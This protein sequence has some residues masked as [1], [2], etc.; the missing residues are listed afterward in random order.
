MKNETNKN[1]D[2]TVVGR[3]KGNNDDNYYLIYACGSNKERAL[4]VLEKAKK[5]ERL[6]EKYDEFK[7]NEVEAKDAWWY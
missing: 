5:E 4:E 1:V 3:L 7:L 2:Y 6:L